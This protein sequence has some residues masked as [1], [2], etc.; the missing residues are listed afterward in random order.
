MSLLLLFGK[1]VEVAPIWRDKD[2]DTLYGV[3]NRTYLGGFRP[4]P[5]R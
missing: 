4:K 5:R 1:G 3:T 2:R